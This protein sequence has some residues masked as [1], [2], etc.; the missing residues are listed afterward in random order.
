MAMLSAPAL[1][2]PLSARFQSPAA[3]SRATA[4][5]IARQRP[6]Y[7]EAGSFS[8]QP[9][10]SAAMPGAG[11]MPAWTDVGRPRNPIELVGDG[12]SERPSGTGGG[13]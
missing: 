4:T 6:G 10:P 2:V 5:E 12:G 9:L 13:K 1:A 3:A 11:A 8:L 7:A